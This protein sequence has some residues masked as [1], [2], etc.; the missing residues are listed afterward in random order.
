[1]IDLN[2]K[3]QIKTT[4]VIYPQIYAFTEP[5]VANNNGW[6]KIGYTEQKNVDARIK[7]ITHTAGV[8]PSKLWSE[9]AKYSHEDKWFK[10]YQ[11]HDYLTRF[12]SIDRRIGTE[13]F[14]FDGTPEKALEDFNDFRG[15]HFSQEKEQAEYTLRAEQEKAVNDTLDYANSHESGEYLWNAKPRFGKTLTTYDF[16]RKFGAD[17]VL[18]V[19][20]RPAIAN[21]WFDDFEK[22]IAWQTDYAFVSTSDSLNERPVLTR[23][24]FNKQLSALDGK[25]KMIA[26]IS[27]QDLKGAIPFGG[28][29]NKLTWVKDLQWDLLVIDEAHEGVDTFKADIA[30][31]K[32]KTKFTL[33]L[34]GTPFKQVASGKFSKDQ[35]FNWTYQDEQNAKENWNDELDEHNPYEKLPRLNLFSYQM[36][37]MITDEVNQG[38]EI[39]G[40]NIDYAFDLNEFF[41][42]T[43]SGKFVHELDV[44]KWLDT[45]TQNEKYPFSTKELRTELKHTFWLLNR[46]ASAKALEKLLKN[47]PVFEN[48]EIILAAGDGKTDDDQ[49]INEKSLDRVRKAIKEHDR[50]ITLSVG[51]LTTGI[52]IPEWTAV[53][54]LSNIKSPSLYMQAA[55]RSQNPYEFEL[56]GQMH[57][58][59][60]AYVFDFAPERTLTIYD[61]FA[62]NLASDTANGG[63]TTEHRKDNIEELLNFFPVIAED[64]A[65]QMVELDVNQVLTIPK[66][67]KAK[68]VVKRGFMSNLLFQNISHIFASE[69]AREI[70]DKLDPAA[71]GKNRTQKSD[72]PI[73]TQG[74]E[75]DEN[76]NVQVDNEIVIA[77]TE[78]HFGEKVY[79]NVNGLVDDILQNDDNGKSL[80]NQIAT[81]F[82]HNIENTVKELAKEHGLTNKTAEQIV[83]QGSNAIAREIE[84]TQ[85]NADIKRNELKIECQKAIQESSNDAEKVAEA[86][87]HFEAQNKAVDEELKQTIFEVV[88]TKTKEL[89]QESTK[90]VLEKAEDKKKNTVED[91]VRAH[92]RGFARTIPSFL[93]AYGEIDTTLQNFDENIDEAVFEEVTSIT[94]DEFRELRDDLHFFDEVVFNES[95]QEF[96]RKRADLAHYYTEQSQ[97]DI[98]DYIP[99]Q[100][101][102]QIFTPKRVVKMMV[103]TLQEEHPE[104]FT[105]KDTTFIDLYMKSG[106]FIVEVARRLFIGIAE[107]IPDENQRIKH[108]LEQQVYGIV[109]TPILDA[110]CRELIFGFTKVDSGE[111]AWTGGAIS[112]DN[113]REIDLTEVAK[114]GRVKDVLYEKFGPVGSE[115]K[116]MIKFDVVIGNPPYQEDIEGR[117]EQPPVY[118]YFLD[119]GYEISNFACFIHPARFLFNAGKTSAKWNQKMLNDP[120]LKVVKFVQNSADLF[121]NTDIKGG[122]CITLRDITSVD[123]GLKGTFI[124]FA[125]L[126]SILNKVKNCG[127]SQNLGDI[128]YS[129]TSY[130][131]SDKIYQDNPEFKNRVSGGSV[132]YLS[133]S[134]F[135]KFHEV[136]YD[137]EP[138][139]GY[140]YAQIIGLLNGKRVWKYMREDYLRPPDN[141]KSYKVILPASNGSGAIGEVF[142]TP[143]VGEPLVGNTETFIS[144]GKFEREREFKLYELS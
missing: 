116:N 73:D 76:G 9:P 42:T 41:E 103:D 50:T 28:T 98:F 14:Y 131:Y 7:Q 36:S 135:E 47:H 33:N 26:F 23:E 102:N 38:A 2:N 39:N 82:K 115:G 40:E 57:Q 74:V 94:L 12:K 30:F 17:K 93:M 25:K 90:T 70:L 27:L 56:D 99:P 140:S 109:P 89:A 15:G 110:I 86:K 69:R 105:S 126:Q 37:Q 63:G 114:Q 141:Y 144:F 43:D 54:M 66:T 52:T 142:S 132:R 91:D 5:E 127:L 117:G 96:L 134:V 44:K 136:M 58:K 113:F 61:E 133:S 32:I 139:E 119:A 128:L 104:L 16:A 48:Y 62:N 143:L 83:Q 112:Q 64:E 21:S 72:K 97:E 29:F 13:W 3:T 34:S 122:V 121:P 24:D 101:T 22:F 59:E 85:K 75:V 31:D 19:T 79:G 65:G 60:N 88:E 123:G 68:E 8:T 124:H 35:I 11:F 6:I 67:V 4:K 107:Q 125:E 106:L 49:I 81:A 71:Q 84:I 53:M 108:I 51:Q 111:N 129:N 46:V 80:S 87:A 18:V 120:Y 1:M 20:N 95:V 137:S 100:K 130:K 45:L 92:L 10:D 78:A 77:Q 138:E 55:F 118:N